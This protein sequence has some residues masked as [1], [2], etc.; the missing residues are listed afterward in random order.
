MVG[1]LSW[2]RFK[3]WTYGGA[4]T[5]VASFSAILKMFEFKAMKL[6]R[7]WWGS[8]SMWALSWLIAISICE[9][10][11]M[12]R[13]ETACCEI[14]E[15]FG[16]RD[17]AG[18]RNCLNPARCMNIYPLALKKTCQKDSQRV[19]KVDQST[20]ASRRIKSSSDTPNHS[21]P[22]WMTWNLRKARCQ[23]SE[24]QAVLYN[25]IGLQ[26]VDFGWGIS[27]AGRSVP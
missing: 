15:A 3:R 12:A 8:W 1:V 27:G 5:T 10:T 9:S 26:G 7:P 2:C 19:F 23:I 18:K 22:H 11:R 14:F 13:H 6:G 25:K 4:A 20:W 21:L 24:S 17:R 16:L